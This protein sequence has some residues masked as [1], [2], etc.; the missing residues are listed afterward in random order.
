MHVNRED[1]PYMTYGHALAQKTPT[2]GYYEIY[3]FGEIFLGHHYYLLSLSDLCLG[4]E[5]RLS[6]K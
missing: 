1:F 2:P 5:K 4:V 3:Y 6:K